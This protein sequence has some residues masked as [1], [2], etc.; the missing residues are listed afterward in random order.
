MPNYA[1]S[2]ILLITGKEDKN[3]SFLFATTLKISMAMSDLRSKYRKYTQGNETYRAYYPLIDEIGIDS[4]MGTII[5][6]KELKTRKELNSLLTQAITLQKQ[7]NRKYTI[8]ELLKN[9]EIEKRPIV[10]IT[11]ERYTANIR[12]LMKKLGLPESESDFYKDTDKV[13]GFI[14]N[15]IL[16]LETQ[17]NYYKALVYLTPEDDTASNIYKQKI[18]S[19]LEETKKIIAKNKL[20]PAQIK[21]WI[22]YEDVLKIHNALPKYSFEYMIS[23]FYCGIYFPPWRIQELALLK[24][25]N[26]N[27]EIDNYIDFENNSIVLNKYKTVKSYGRKVQKIPQE[28]INDI[29]KYRDNMSDESEIYRLQDYLLTNKNFGR[30]SEF[31]IISTLQKIYGASCD[32]L[33]HSYI[34]HLIDTGKLQTVRERNIVADGMR[35]DIK[36]LLEYYKVNINDFDSSNTGNYVSPYAPSL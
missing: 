29:Y 5:I 28:F 4:L 11:R 32:I 10:M 6:E 12:I 17:R 2:K 35:H 13:I 31:V 9:A 18:L 22:D 30:I 7:G 8:P 19:N 27:P 36:T 20:T 26:Y 3:K 15:S 16:A 23:L 33:R 24:T 34:T 14:D 21:T 25:D 1:N